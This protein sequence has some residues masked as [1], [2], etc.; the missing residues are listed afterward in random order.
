M[1]EE[2]ESGKQVTESHV[3][4]EAILDVG[5]MSI[6]ETFFIYAKYSGGQSGMEFKIKHG[7]PLFVKNFHHYDINND[8]MIVDVVNRPI[9]FE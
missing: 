1:K 4:I 5:K 7:A 6:F 9:V 2:W 3:F 8:K